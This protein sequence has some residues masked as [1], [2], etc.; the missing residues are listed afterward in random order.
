MNMERLNGTQNAVLTL[1]KGLFYVIALCG[2]VIR[3]G[4]SNIVVVG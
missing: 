1:D 3:L 2:R 4:N